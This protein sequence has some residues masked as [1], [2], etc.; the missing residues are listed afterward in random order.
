MLRMLMNKTYTFGCRSQFLCEKRTLGT[1]QREDS[2][3]GVSEPYIR[4]GEVSIAEENRLMRQKPLQ[5][6]LAGKGDV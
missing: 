6:K 4:Y 3:W 5:R 1:P 2:L